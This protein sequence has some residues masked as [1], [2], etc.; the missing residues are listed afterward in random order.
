T[1][2]LR[3]DFIVHPYQVYEAKVIGADAILLIAADLATAEYEVLL[4]LAHSLGLEVLLEVHDTKELDYLKVA[5]PD[6]LGVNNRHLGTFHTDVQVSFRI[7]ALMQEKL[8]NL[9]KAGMKEEDLPVLVSESGISNPE[10]VKALRQVGFRG[11][12]IGECFMKEED[13]GLALKS[14]IQALEK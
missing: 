7:A 9:R 1:P 13:P 3:K 8:D 10:T 5:I 14:F 12:L 6:M 4:S 2:I 11:F